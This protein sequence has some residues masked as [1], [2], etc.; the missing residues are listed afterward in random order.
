M[1]YVVSTSCRDNIF[2]YYLLAQRSVHIWIC[3]RIVNVK[4]DKPSFKLLVRSWVD[5]FYLNMIY[6]NLK[7]LI[8][9]SNKSSLANRILQW[10]YQYISYVV[11][12][13]CMLS[14]A[15]RITSAFRPYSHGT[16]AIAINFSL[17]PQSQ[18]M[19]IEPIHCDAVAIVA[20][21]HLHCI[22]YNPLVAMKKSQS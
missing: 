16:T 12:L 3:M 9:L 4:I 7:S 10:I 2:M 1:Y 22:P 19:G 6:H 18:W 20:C 17:Q 13:S 15:F 11:R 5:H 14:P 8:Y 21:Q